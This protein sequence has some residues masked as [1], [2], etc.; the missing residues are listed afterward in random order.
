MSGY[1]SCA[2]NPAL[3]IPP[4]DSEA[5]EN[6]TNHAP[7]ASVKAA[8]APEEVTTCSEGTR[9]VGA[10]DAAQPRTLLEKSRSAGEVTDAQGA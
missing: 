6:D 1:A 10:G 2:P 8:R 9:V 7:G 4:S 5:A 3:V